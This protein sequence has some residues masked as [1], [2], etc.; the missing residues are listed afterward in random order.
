MAPSLLDALKSRP[1]IM[2]TLEQHAIS[3][4][5]DVVEG[6]KRGHEKL[7]AWVLSHGLTVVLEEVAR[8]MASGSVI[9]IIFLIAALQ[10]SI[11]DLC[12][13]CLSIR[14]GF[15]LNS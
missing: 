11:D 9:Y 7:M 12:N 5:L 10:I 14:L 1:Q 6:E 4:F 15:H 13:Q 3:R 8:E 2:A